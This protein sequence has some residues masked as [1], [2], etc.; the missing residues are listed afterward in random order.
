LL[1]VTVGDVKVTNFINK[2]CSLLFQFIIVFIDNLLEAHTTAWFHQIRNPSLNSSRRYRRSGTTCC[3]D[4]SK[5]AVWNT[6]LKPCPHCRRKVRLSHEIETVAQKWD[7]CRK[8]RLS[9]NLSVFCDSLT[10]LRQCGQGLKRLM[11]VWKL[12]IDNSS[13][14]PTSRSPSDCKLFITLFECRMTMF[15][16]SVMHGAPFV[17]QTFCECEREKWWLHARAVYSITLS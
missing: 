9:P 12:N 10:F 11:P 7:C 15:F 17:L 5:N 4:Q 2:V 1:W 8:V 6:S 16:C 13:M 14:G 3:R